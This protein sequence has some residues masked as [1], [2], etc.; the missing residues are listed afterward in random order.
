MRSSIR[1]GWLLVSRLLGRRRPRFVYAVGPMS[2]AVRQALT[3]GGGWEVVRTAVAPGISL[4]GI[5]RRPNAL[6]APWILFFPGNDAKQLATAQKF[7]NRVRGDRDWGMA[8]WAYRGFDSSDGV[9]DRDALVRDATRIFDGLLVS[10]HLDPARVHLAAFSLGGYLAASVAGVAANG[11][12][13][14]A[15]LSLLAAVENIAMVHASWA[16]RLVAGEV[17]EIQPLLEAVLGPV[18]VI[19]G[20]EDEALGVDQGR[21][22]A[23]RLGTRARYVELQGAGHDALLESEPAFGAVRAMIEPS[24]P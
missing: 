14:P 10:E 13:K 21:K 23:A 9:P 24:S 4:N 22:I 8:V 5:V 11:G 17:Y 18:L 15:S 7:L 6:D 12:K 1:R 3:A 20:T 16:Q 19:S 2:P